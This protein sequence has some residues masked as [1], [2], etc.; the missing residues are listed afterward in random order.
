VIIEPVLGLGEQS[1]VWTLGFLL[2]ATTIAVSGLI[3]VALGRETA[4]DAHAEIQT[5][6]EAAAPSV[7]QR[8]RWVLFSAVP[9]GLLVAF[10]THLSTDIAAAPFRKLYRLHY[11]C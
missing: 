10:T 4:S 5:N 2:L 6:V 9:S 11:S 8:A 3:M 7:M 1:T